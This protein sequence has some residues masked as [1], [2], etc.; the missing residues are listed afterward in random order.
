MQIM[1][2]SE[3][4]DSAGHHCHL[5]TRQG[6]TNVLLLYNPTASNMALRVV[7]TIHRPNRRPEGAPPLIALDPSELSY[8]ARERI[9][10]KVKNMLGSKPS[11]SLRKIP[12]DERHYSWMDARKL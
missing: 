4:H 8:S 10:I 12:K 9:Y 7:Y 2:I 6:R 3:Q 5:K 11:K 1:V